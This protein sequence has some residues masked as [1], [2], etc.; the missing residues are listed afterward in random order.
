MEESAS[1]HLPKHYDS[2]TSKSLL[3]KCGI[4]TPWLQWYHNPIPFASQ[5]NMDSEPRLPRKR[6]MCGSTPPA[7]LKYVLRPMPKSRHTLF[8][9]STF[10]TN[11][12]KLGVESWWILES[13]VAPT[14]SC[15]EHRN[16]VRICDLG[17]T[18]RHP[19]S[20]QA[21]HKAL[22]SNILW[23]NNNVTPSHIRLDGCMEARWFS[24]GR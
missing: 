10:G 2:W 17:L 5:K 3:N 22:Y 19:T 23:R 16:S 7:A 12:G 4:A 20:S 21:I 18:Y 9:V 6:T 8:T 15:R 13:V 14:S 1:V 11:R 24:K